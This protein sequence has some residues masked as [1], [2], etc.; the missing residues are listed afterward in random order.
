MGAFSGFGIMS[1]CAAGELLAAHVSGAT[2]PDYASAF[3]LD[4][5]EDPAYL[6]QFDGVS[7]SGQ[8]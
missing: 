6:S 8:I 5:Y 1:A 3:S 2:L 7:S 4:R